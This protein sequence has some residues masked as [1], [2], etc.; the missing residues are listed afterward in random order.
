MAVM[1]KRLIISKNH[2][3][4][5][6]YTSDRGKTRLTRH[7]R[8]PPHSSIRFLRVVHI[9]GNLSRSYQPSWTNSL[10]LRKNDPDSTLNPTE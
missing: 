4:S 6:R 8:F 2:N 7:V 1:N 5:N 9:Y 10:F 3:D